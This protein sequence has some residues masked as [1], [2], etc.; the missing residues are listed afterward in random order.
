MYSENELTQIR[1]S[2]IQ[3]KRFLIDEACTNRA[4]FKSLIRSMDRLTEDLFKEMDTDSSLKN[5]IKSELY[6]EIR[7]NWNNDNLF[8]AVLLKNGKFGFYQVQL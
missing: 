1:S 7:K 3:H 2:W 8:E 5:T 6:E 4:A